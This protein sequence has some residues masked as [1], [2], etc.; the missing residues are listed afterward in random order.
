MSEQKKPKENSLDRVV[1]ES[2]DLVTILI[3]CA[4]KDDWYFEMVGNRML[5]RIYKT[6]RNV[7]SFSMPSNFIKDGDFKV[8][9]GKDIRMKK[10]NKK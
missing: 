3:T 8:I 5:V 2:G 9:K 6:K 7:Q 10:E 4:K 1:Q